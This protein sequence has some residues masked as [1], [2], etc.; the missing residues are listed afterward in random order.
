MNINDLVI[1]KMDLQNREKKDENVTFG[2][3]RPIWNFSE[4]EESSGSEGDTMTKKIVA[5][6]TSPLS[7]S[8]SS[9]F[10]KEANKSSTETNMHDIG[11]TPV[12]PMIE[13]DSVVHIIPIENATNGT[14]SYM[15]LS[16]NQEEIGGVKVNLGVGPRPAYDGKLNTNYFK[17]YLKLIFDFK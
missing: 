9:K 12:L 13:T 7:C 15:V 2:R 5:N 16:L 11:V 17:F 8:E 6:S 4:G 1:K 10:V 3:K 14:V